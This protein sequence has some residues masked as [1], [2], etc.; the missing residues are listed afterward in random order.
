[1]QLRILNLGSQ[2]GH[3]DGSDAVGL[4]GTVPRQLSELQQL[5]E[6]NLESNAHC[7]LI[8]FRHALTLCSF[9]GG[10]YHLRW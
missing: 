6:L 2:F 5:R 10:S 8:F 1:L 7:V 9:W 3:N 4:T